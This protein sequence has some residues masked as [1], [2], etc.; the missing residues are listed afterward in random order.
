MS[1]NPEAL[2]DPP[3]NAD[4]YLREANAEDPRSDPGA[5]ATEPG[6]SEPGGQEPDGGKTTSRE[7]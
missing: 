1:V 4:E 2:G 6:G 7:L 5:P 3:D